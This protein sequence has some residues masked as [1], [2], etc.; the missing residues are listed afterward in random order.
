VQSGFVNKYLPV[1]L[2][3]CLLITTGANNVLILDNNISQSIVIC[4]YFSLKLL[5]DNCLELLFQNILFTEV[6]ILELPR[7]F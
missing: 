7:F 3:N 1:T 5:C 6:T 4:I 2:S